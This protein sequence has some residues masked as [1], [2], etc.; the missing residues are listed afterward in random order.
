MDQ[1]R[2]ICKRTFILFHRA[3]SKH[4]SRQERVSR[5]KFHRLQYLFSS[6]YSPHHT[7]IKSHICVRVQTTLTVNITPLE[8]VVQTTD[9]LYLSLFT[10]SS[11]PTSA[12]MNQ[13][14]N[15]SLT[16]F[17]SSLL[18]DE[19]VTSFNIV[20]DNAKP[21]LERM[22]SVVLVSDEPKCRWNNLVRQDSDPIRKVLPASGGDDR[23]PTRRYSS[24]PNLPQM[25]ERTTSPQT[26]ST[27][28]NFKSSNSSKETMSDSNLLL[29]MPK[30]QPSP[31]KTLQKPGVI[32]ASWEYWNTTS[33]DTRI[34]HKNMFLGI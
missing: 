8:A 28:R 26:T 3:R 24:D 15:S 2:D 27:P 9:L 6:S 13:I 34:R 19:E 32:N 23:R 18:E 29:R 17:L 12:T 22:M 11:L 33:V 10:L 25:P 5:Q 7:H 31:K 16:S 20:A 30:R 4:S 1:K 21:N 14:G